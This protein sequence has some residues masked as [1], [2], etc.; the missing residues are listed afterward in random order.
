MGLYQR[1]VVPRLVALAMTNREFVP[2]RRRI[3]SLARGRVLEI[4]IG[5]ALNLPFYGTAVSDVI[6]VDPS[7]TLARMARTRRAEVPFRRPRMQWRR[8]SAG[9]PQH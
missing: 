1:Y 2:Y 6:G 8:H 5:S 7:T 4:G 9:E 3:A